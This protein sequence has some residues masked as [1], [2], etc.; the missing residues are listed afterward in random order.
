ML[1]LL[2]LFYFYL[3]LSLPL[4]QGNDC[5]WHLLPFYSPHL[6]YDTDEDW[7]IQISDREQSDIYI[8]ATI[9]NRRLMFGV[10]AKNNAGKYSPNFRAAEQFRAVIAHLDG[11][12]DIILG[13]WYSGDNMSILN[14]FTA[15]G[16]SLEEAAS[17]T[18]TGKQAASLGYEKVHVEYVSGT[19][20]RYKEVIVGFKK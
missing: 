20:G 6:Q 8:K 15:Q 5:N 17:Q 4:A 2:V 13:T 9:N 18:W 19:S 1:K 7:D 10:E 14:E 16:M 12:F 11:Q 3:L